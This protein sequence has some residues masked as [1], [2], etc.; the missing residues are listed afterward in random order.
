M[1]VIWNSLGELY[2]FRRSISQ[3]KNTDLREV[4]FSKGFQANLL[5]LCPRG[6]KLLDYFWQ[7][8][9]LFSCPE[10][11]TISIYKEYFLYEHLWKRSLRTKIDDVTFHKTYR[12]LRPTHNCFPATIFCI[13]LKVNLSICKIGGNFKLVSKGQVW[14]VQPN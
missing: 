6:R 11:D 2:T 9:N 12:K 14:D 8:I 10:W 7:Q 1:D 13:W 3:L 5:N 4:Q